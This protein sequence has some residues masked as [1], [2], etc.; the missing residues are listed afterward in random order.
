M[1]V[2]A[3]SQGTYSRSATPPAQQ[4]SSNKIGGTEYFAYL[5][6]VH[7]DD[8]TMAC[9]LDSGAGDTYMSFELFKRLTVPRLLSK[10]GW[11]DSSSTQ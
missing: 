5:V 8:E 6:D 7:T 2:D 9:V 4:S 11:R 1:R 3:M 10:Q